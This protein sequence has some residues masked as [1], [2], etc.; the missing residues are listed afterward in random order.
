MNSALLKHCVSGDRVV[1]PR[2]GGTLSSRAWSVLASIWLSRDDEAVLE[3]SLT[4]SAIFPLV[5]GGGKSV[6]RPWV[7]FVG[8][9]GDEVVMAANGVQT[10]LHR[11]GTMRRVWVD[12]VQLLCGLRLVGDGD[13]ASRYMD[14]ELLE[15]FGV[16]LEQSGV[17][18]KWLGVAGS[19]FRLPDVTV[20]KGGGVGEIGRRV[21]AEYWGEFVRVQQVVGLTRLSDLVGRR[22]GLVA[23]TACKGSSKGMALDGFA[24][25]DEDGQLGHRLSSLGELRWFGLR[26][27]EVWVANGDR[28]LRSKF[29]RIAVCFRSALSVGEGGGVVVPGSVSVDD[30]AVGVF[31]DHLVSR[32]L[33]AF[34]WNLV[35]QYGAGVQTRLRE[36]VELGVQSFRYLG[37]CGTVKD[38]AG[39]PD[40]NRRHLASVGGEFGE[41]LVASERPRWALELVSRW[42]DGG[43]LGPGDTMLAKLLTSWVEECWVA[44]GLGYTV[45]FD[46]QRDGDGYAGMTALVLRGGSGALERV[47]EAALLRL[48]DEENAGIGDEAKKDPRF[49]RVSWFG[50]SGQRSFADQYFSTVASKYYPA[51]SEL[52]DRSER[53]GKTVTSFVND[54]GAVVGVSGICLEGL[55]RGY[56]RYSGMGVAGGLGEFWEGV[57]RKSVVPAWR[58]QLVREAWLAAY[59]WAWVE[60]LGFGGRG[61]WLGVFE[62]LRGRMR[63]V[64]PV[65]GQM[66]CCQWSGS[67][68]RWNGEIIG[69][70]PVS[71]NR[72]GVYLSL[73]SP[74]LLQID[75]LLVTGMQG[76]GGVGVKVDMDGR[77]VNYGVNAP[78]GALGWGVIGGPRMESLLAPGPWRAHDDGTWEALNTW[79]GGRRILG[80]CNEPYLAAI[81]VYSGMLSWGSSRGAMV[82]YRQGL[83]GHLEQMH[84]DPA[85]LDLWTPAGVM[86]PSQWREVAGCLD[87]SGVSMLSLFGPLWSMV[88]PECPPE[89]HRLSP[90][91]GKLDGVKFSV[92]G[93]GYQSQISTWTLDAFLRIWSKV[94]A[95]PLAVPLYVGGLSGGIGVFQLLVRTMR[96][97]MRGVSPVDLA[98]L[99]DAP[100]GITGRDAEEFL[101]CRRRIWGWYFAGRLPR[102]RPGY[103]GYGVSDPLPLDPPWLRADFVKLYRAFYRYNGMPD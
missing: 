70:P 45:G 3:Y 40:M 80:V 1:L 77:T 38:L 59:L 42:G 73:E 84:V 36:W 82:G 21:G 15:A 72:L 20:L 75:Y 53:E 91:T 67:P 25:M 74:P 19:P 87:P 56:L 93:V 16:A 10:V 88:A 49:S 101:E 4:D 37:G 6:V 86:A 32:V 58:W 46:L 39:I 7:E 34:R 100:A 28:A 65:V 41:G 103:A 79:E 78:G 27:G 69:R 95:S 2:V 97:V 43:E 8:P 68:P 92:G 102:L 23:A 48:R 85:A 13:V 12:T 9:G 99:C 17:K 96:A 52:R 76:G 33:P 62:D 63:R 94:E 66:C 60:W 90:L 22:C 83:A 64:L 50:D 71:D 47:S 11:V 24:N 89:L 61:K 35:F 5:W 14:G 29:N 30:R 98:A 31:G 51:W 44:V 81:R 57:G 26:N 54:V 55:M 18:V